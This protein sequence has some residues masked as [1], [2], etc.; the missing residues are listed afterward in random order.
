MQDLN[1]FKRYELKYL[2]TQEKYDNII[3]TIKTYAQPDEHKQNTILSLYYD[4]PNSLLIRRSIEKPVYKEKLRLRSYGVAMQDS[5]VYVELK[6][7]Y[8]DVVF[9]RRIDMKN[10]EADLFMKN[11]YEGKNC[12]ITNEINYF[13]FLYHDLAPAMLIMYNRMAYSG[14]SNK[15]LRITFDNNIRFRNYD[16]SLQK[17]VYGEKIEF[18][19]KY[20]MEI[21]TGSCIPL[22]LSQLLT[23]NEIYKTG[24]SKYGNAYKTI[25]S[26]ANLNQCIDKIG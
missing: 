13:K 6:K 17:G 26:R 15:D 2:L 16:L 24:F 23:E 1:V 22:W 20:L 9:K 18:N 7:K 5:K 12:Q 10:D 3:D 25:L 19:G 4:T 21:K 11:K 14:E 8:K